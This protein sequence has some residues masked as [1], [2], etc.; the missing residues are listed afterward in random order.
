MVVNGAF[1]SLL[2]FLIAAFDRIGCDVLLVYPNLNLGVRLRD[3]LTGGDICALDRATTICH[4]QLQNGS[5]AVVGLCG[6]AHRALRS[7]PSR[8]G[9]HDRHTVPVFHL[10]VRTI[11]ESNVFIIHVDVYE[12]PDTSGGSG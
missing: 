2:N 5:Q 7:T 11:Q 8:D 4:R 9:R 3:I 1:H 6:N 12:S 10:R